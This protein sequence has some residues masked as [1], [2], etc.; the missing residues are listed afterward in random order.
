MCFSATAS[1]TGGA[2]LSLIGFATIRKN[3]EPAQRLF[4]AIPIVFGVQ[5]I[6]EGFVW[7]ALQSPGHDL[8]LKVATYIFLLAAV[9]VWPT[10]LP[11]SILL[12]TKP[13]PK[14][15]SV[16]NLFLAVGIAVSVSYGIGLLLFAVTAQI[17][18]FHILY[19]MDTPRSLNMVGSIA[20]L[21]ATIPILFVTKSTKIFLFG[22]IIVIAY[23]ATQIFFR[24]YLVSVW[25]FFAALASVMIW[26]I[27]KE[28]DKSVELLEKMSASKT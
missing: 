15:I 7:L 21:L 13:K 5:Q 22:I 12:M 11:L 2:I 3:Q 25:C 6:A 23:A 18:N 24:D 27:V 26:W 20:Y 1:F 17:S 14:Q 9:V 19:S 8:I 10:M 4:A 16:L 28:P